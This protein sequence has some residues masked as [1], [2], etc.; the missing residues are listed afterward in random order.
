MSVVMKVMLVDDH[1][2]FLEGLQYL[3]ETHGI[4][5]IGKARDGNEALV[6]AKIL[7]PDII[8]MD[9]R[10]PNCNGIHALRQIKTELPEIKIVMLTT[11]EEEED[12]FQAVKY[13]ASGYLLKDTD[14]SSLIK[15]LN[16]LNQGC[17]PLTAG[18]A[19]RIMTEFKSDAGNDKRESKHR[20]ED[21]DSVD[22]TIRQIEILEL[23]TI[24]STYKEVGAKLGLTEKTVKYHM[25]RIVELLQLKNKSQVI[26]YAVR[27]GIV[28]DK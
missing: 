5:V 15:L 25:G 19:A 4:Q 10:M 27:T 13:G 20:S 2:L 22:L 24:G 12:I 18:L 17:V 6:K 11:S 28:Q 21:K 23:V 14:A 26:Q 9:I 16:D 7:R 1:K 3:L 8:L